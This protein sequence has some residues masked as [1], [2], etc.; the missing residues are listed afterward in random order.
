MLQLPD[1][2]ILEPLRDA[3]TQFL[4]RLNESA[5]AS[6]LQSIIEHFEQQPAQAEEFARICAISQFVA[7]SSVS[8]SELLLE[9]LMSGDLQRDYSADELQLRLQ[10]SITAE[11]NLSE[12][13]LGKMLRVLRRR[14]MMRVIWRDLNRLSSLSQLTHELSWLADACLQNGLRF[15]HAS[16]CEQYGTPHGDSDDGT[17]T[18][19]HLVVIGMGKLGA[20]E[21]NLSSDIDLMF[22]YPSAGSTQGGRKSISNNE[23][24]TRLGQRLIKLIDQQSVDG[25]VFRVDMRLRPY[26]QS[27]ALAMS[28]DAMNEYYQSQGRDWERYAMIKARIVAGDHVAGAQLLLSLRPFVYRRYIDF[29]VFESLRSMKAMIVRE[30]ARKNLGGNIKLGAG[31]IREIE[32]IAQAFQLLRGGR[33]TALQTRGLLDVMPLLEAEGLLPAAAVVQLTEAYDYLR[34]VEHTLQAMEDRQTQELP[35]TETDCLRLAFALGSSSWQE[36]SE[37]LAQHRDNVSQHFNDTIEPASE[38]EDEQVEAQAKLWEEVWDVDV[39]QEEALQKLT[40]A[41]FV[42]ADAAWRALSDLH[43]DAAYM[44]SIGLARL[45]LLMPLLMARCAEAGNPDQTLTRVLPLLKS[46]LRRSA[47][48]LLL[49]ENRQALQHLIELCNASPWIAEQ[50]AKHP[51]LLDELLDARTLFQ[52]PD[53][54]EL[55]ASLRQQMLRIDEHDQ[56][57]QMEQ[58]RYFRMSYGL[59]VAAAEVSG[60]LPL[61]KVSDYLTFIAEAILDY[62]LQ[63]AWAQLVVK[64]GQPEDCVQQGGPNFIIVAYGKLGGIELGHDSDLDLVFVHEGNATAITDGERPLDSLTLYIRLGQ[65][66]IH[67]LNTRTALGQLYEVDM[68]LRPSGNSGLLVSSVKAFEEYQ[69]QQAWTWEHQALVRARVVVGPA[70]LA[71]WFEQFRQ[72]VLCQQRDPSQLREDVSAM[73]KK[74]RDNLLSGVAEGEFHLKHSAGGIVDIEFMVQY[75]VLLWSAQQ[76]DLCRYTDNIRILESLEAVG[77]F[78]ADD[79]EQL[80]AAYKTYRTCLHRRT[81][82]Q[83]SALIDVAQLQNERKVVLQKWRELFEE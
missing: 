66:I 83:E 67:I 7:D 3:L 72:R 78:S 6:V 55:Q 14:E 18:E 33:D 23:F 5:D 17:A 20:H 27:G 76:A 61:M 32:F 56:E 57:A 36:F 42:D 25:F 79:A 53:R 1:A 47:Y 41:G 28:F 15:L 26:G 50:L 4:R 24:F 38:R 16:C 10:A 51:A 39:D 58:L 12:D 54:A 80:R 13:A 70:A 35:N 43:G 37:C 77:L 21:L 22:A 71:N 2:H 29:S 48:L 59:R 82:Q 69:L 19:Q 8:H 46:V 9:L 30:V 40:A 73:R 74:M 11:Q 63:L 68:R 34:N 49:T 81:L 31:G 44:Q 62:V 64:H 75:V 65:R 45:D 60:A 52:P